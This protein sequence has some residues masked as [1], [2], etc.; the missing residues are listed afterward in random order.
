M[1]YTVTKLIN[2]A[3][4]KS[5]I[6]SREFGTVPGDK[7][8]VG[9]DELNKLLNRKTI[10]QSL[11]PYYTEYTDNFV[12]GQ[13]GYTIPGLISIDT[14][15][16]NIDSVRYPMTEYKRKQYF[17]TGRSD[18]VESLPY[19]YHL[20]PVFTGGKV[21]LYFKP[22][23]VYPFTIW[24]K[25]RLSGVTLNQDLE[26]TQ[27]LFYIG[28]LEVE[29]ANQLCNEYNFAIPEGLKADL[30]QYRIDIKNSVAP[31][32]TQITKK[33]TLSPQAEVGFYGQVNLGKG[34]VP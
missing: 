29:L 26:L 21:F 20:E 5:G 31:L 1:T 25:F 2:N 19:S 9:L 30:K 11:I 15:T 34:W 16:F 32:D 24:G 23:G 3:F 17:A 18:N 12:I 33:S 13:E 4:Y 22:R 8:A 6:V 7:V 14:M 28:F 10:R 27:D